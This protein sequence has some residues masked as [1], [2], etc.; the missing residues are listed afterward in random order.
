MTRAMRRYWAVAGTVLAFLLVGFLVAEAFDFPLLVDPTP[1][2]AGGGV[3]G[4]ILAV[5]LITV[6]AVLPVPASLVIVASGA[7]YG[8]VT[9][10]LLALLG[11]VLMALAGYA[12]GQR[13]GPLIA[14]LVQR[15]GRDRAD[16]LLRRW[17]P[18]AIVI[19]RPVP[20][21]AETVTILAGASSIGWGRVA[22]AALVGSVPEAVLY[23][24]SGALTRSVEEAGLVWLALLIVACSFWI[25]CRWADRRLAASG[26]PFQL[27][28]VRTTPRTA[29][30]IGRSRSWRRSR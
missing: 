14:R 20:L 24:G 6:D 22:L 2:L 3:L 12:I 28:G 15:D 4:A 29:S 9:G 19:T 27:L 23:A 25:V 1:R 30:G 7:L 21:L 17:G 5:A 10:A 26:Q 18:I 16:E 13:G 8:M 11:R